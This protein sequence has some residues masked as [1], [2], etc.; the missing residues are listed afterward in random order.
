VIDHLLRLPLE[1]DYPWSEEER[2]AIL[3][4]AFQVH[5][6]LARKKLRI[7]VAETA[8]KHALRMTDE[9]LKWAVRESMSYAMPHT[10]C[11]P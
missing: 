11:I 2:G 1:D 7:R 6:Y 10:F 9:E 4:L 5:Q 3:S 8:L